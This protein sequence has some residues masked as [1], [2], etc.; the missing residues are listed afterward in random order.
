MWT[1]V[2]L[3]PVS[4]AMTAGRHSPIVSSPIKLF[5]Q[6]TLVLPHWSVA[7]SQAS[8]PTS[9]SHP[10]SGLLATGCWTVLLQVLTEVLLEVLLLLLAAGTGCCWRRCAGESCGTFRLSC[11]SDPAHPVEREEE[12]RKSGQEGGGGG[13]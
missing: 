1:G 3:A 4:P 7:A 6:P 10:A 8:Q 5:Q 12:R 13:W 2:Q 11:G 9:P